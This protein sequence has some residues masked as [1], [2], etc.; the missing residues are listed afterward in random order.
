MCAND[1]A[2]ETEATVPM[3]PSD[4]TRPDPALVRTC[5]S[6]LL[7]ESFH[8]GTGLLYHQFRSGGMRKLVPRARIRTAFHYGT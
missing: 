5:L 4:G 2:A 7:P 8:F 3:I 6:N 1:F